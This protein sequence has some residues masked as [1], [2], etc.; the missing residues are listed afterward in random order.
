MFKTAPGRLF[1]GAIGALALVAAA[2]G[3]GSKAASETT[4]TVPGRRGAALQG[5]RQCMTSHGVTLP[6]RSRT[7]TTTNGSEPPQSDSGGGFGG[8]GFGGFGNRFRQPPPGVDPAKYQAAFQACQSQLPNP[9]NNAQFQS[10][11]NAYVGC[12]KSHGVN[13]GDPSQG[14]QALSGIDRN[15]ATFQA[16][17][18]VC[19]PLLPTRG[20]SSTTSTTA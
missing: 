2:C 20:S 11:F 1:L 18:Q 14:F 16:A 13:V 5:F 19:R 6:Q 10:A 4:T 15:S 17:Q 12:L 7:S 9:Q 3:G 8:F